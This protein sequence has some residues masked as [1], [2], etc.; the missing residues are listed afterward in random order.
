M[1]LSVIQE[2]DV[3]ESVLMLPA[4]RRFGLRDDRRTRRSQKMVQFVVFQFL[5]RPMFKIACEQTDVDM[6][7]LRERFQNRPDAWQNAALLL[8]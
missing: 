8:F 4:P 2:N 1:R 3:V 7:V 6:H 5:S